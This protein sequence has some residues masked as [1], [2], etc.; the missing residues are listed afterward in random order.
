MLNEQYEFS[1][2]SFDL[3]SSGDRHTCLSEDMVTCNIK[4]ALASRSP[5][6][7]RSPWQIP[8]KVLWDRSTCKPGCKG[9]GCPMPAEVDRNIVNFALAELNWGDCHLKEALVE[10]F[11][12]QVTSDS[13][14][15][16]GMN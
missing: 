8:M 6:T 9:K 14:C 5:A 15:G 12:H 7:S 16:V 3:V 4:V 2:Y 13:G 1:V 10:N 11:K